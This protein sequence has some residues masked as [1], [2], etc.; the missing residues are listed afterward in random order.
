[1][2]KKATTFLCIFMFFLVFSPTKIQAQFNDYGWKIGGQVH[3]IITSND[4]ALDNGIE[5]GFL[6]RA[7]AR[8][9]LNSPLDLEIGAGFGKMNGKDNNE[10]SYSANLIPIDVRL[11][12]SPV[13]SDDWNPYLY[14]GIGL[15]SY[16]ADVKSSLGGAASPQPV[17]EDG[18]TAVIPFGLG[19][20]FKLSDELLL[21]VAAGINYSFADDLNYYAKGDFNDAYWNFG[22]GLLFAPE[23]PNADNDNDGL[24]NA[25]EKELGTDPNN[26]DTDGDGLRDGEEFKTFKTDPLN[27]DSDK[28]GLNDYDEVKKHKTNPNM[29]D[30][31]N[32]GLN[33]YDELMKHKTDPNVPDTDG[34]GLNDGDEVNKYKTSPFKTDTD[35][36]GLEDGEEVMKYTTDPLNADTDG[37]TVQ[38]GQEVKNGTNPKDASDDVPK[39]EIVFEIDN[40]LFDFDKAI[41][42]SAGAEILDEVAS[43][44]ETNEEVTIKLI[45]HTCDIG[46]KAYNMKLSEKRAKAAHNY[47]VKKGVDEAK[48]AVEWVGEDSPLVPNNSK[49]NRMKNRSVE[50]KRTD[51]M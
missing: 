8:F 37:G 28:D 10:N 26:A 21:D 46:S 35:M 13:E 18:I 36:D 41:V 38:D 4:F 27:A 20:E 1:M 47:L 7:L 30:T 16:S 42:T 11:L 44:M 2:F 15:L 32:D 51:S 12:F 17:E 22:L 45:G 29:M 14:G 23:N 40:I 39:M 19:A 9:E 3:G 31:D 49:A 34:D 48:I 24:T 6:A 43:I 25:E 50:V 5:L 33:D